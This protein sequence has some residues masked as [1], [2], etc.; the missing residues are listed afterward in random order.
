MSED[1][2][3]KNKEKACHLPERDTQKHN[4]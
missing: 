2:G 3:L 4:A 1:L